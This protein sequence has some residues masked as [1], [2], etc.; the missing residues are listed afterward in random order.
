MRTAKKRSKV[1]TPRRKTAVLS[2][3]ESG[4]SIT[5]ACKQAKVPYATYAS[6]KKSDERFA[7]KAQKILS[8]PEQRARLAAKKTVVA[9]TPGD[10]WKLA[11]TRALRE[12]KKRT[13]ALDI[14]GI[15]AS[16]LQDT[17]AEDMEF[18]A[19][20]EEIELRE[21]MDIEDNLKKRARK[22]TQEARLVLQNVE[23]AILNKY[24]PG[25]KVSKGKETKTS[26][27]TK[28]GLEEADDWLDKVA[29]LPRG[30]IN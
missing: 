9:S 8:Q 21:I 7:E 12:G 1:S 25:K 20:L 19:E 11:Y 17:I 16:T 14:V 22:S 18:A 26:L 24:G 27:Y 2:G 10:N 5:R 28:E 3:L 15:K 30:E 13:E 6:W 29:H 23:G 4:L